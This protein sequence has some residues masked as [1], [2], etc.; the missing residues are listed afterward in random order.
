MPPPPAL[1][2]AFNETTG[3]TIDP[4]SET[5]SIAE[6]DARFNALCEAEAASCPLVD[7]MADEAAT[8]GPEA[9]KLVRPA[10][11]ELARVVC[12][13]DPVHGESI[14]FFRDVTRESEVD[15][16]TVTLWLPMDA[17][18]SQPAPRAAP[19]LRLQ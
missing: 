12:G 7:A 6:F 18:A 14:L 3:L 17:P 8:A 5:V 9:L 10:R 19:A 16:T 2:R 1:N 11:R 15:R 4:D 13:G